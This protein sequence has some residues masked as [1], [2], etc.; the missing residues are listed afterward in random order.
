MFLFYLI[1]IIS[2]SVLYVVSYKKF[3]SVFTKLL[4]TIL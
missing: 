4:L 3:L 1:S 2:L